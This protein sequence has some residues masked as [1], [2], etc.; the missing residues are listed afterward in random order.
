MIVSLMLEMK[1]ARYLII[2]PEK[3]AKGRQAVGRAAGMGPSK[4]LL[5]TPISGTVQTHDRRVGK[6]SL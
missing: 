4:C 2:V 3:R 6:S 5:V 1:L